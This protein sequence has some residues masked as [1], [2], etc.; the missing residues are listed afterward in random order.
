MPKSKQSKQSK[1]MRRCTAL[2]LNCALSKGHGGK[3]E[4][5]PETKLAARSGRCAGKC[6]HEYCRGY[7]DGYGDGQTDAEKAA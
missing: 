3:C 4:P 7:D 2:L 5:R 1:K 6:R